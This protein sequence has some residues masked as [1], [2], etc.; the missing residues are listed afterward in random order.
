VFDAKPQSAGAGGTKHQPVCTARKI[1]IG[2]CVAEELVVGSKILTIDPRFGSPRG[3]SRFENK[4]RFSR[5]SFGNPSLDGTATQPFILEETKTSQVLELLDFPARIETQ[6][7]HAIEPKGTTCCGVEM[8]RDDFTYPR[9]Q[10][11]T[12]R[13]NQFR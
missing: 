7:F 12:M 11:V 5:E 6:L 4:H 10:F 9:I 2:Q 1:F 8:P 3:P 13:L